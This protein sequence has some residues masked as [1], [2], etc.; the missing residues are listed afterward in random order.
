M[1]KG[2]YIALSGALL[3][4]KQLD[5]A[6]QNMANAA[7]SGY[8]KE[9]MSFRNSLIPVDNK[10]AYMADGR[11]MSEVSAVVT[12]FS[13]GGMMKTGNPLDMAIN[14]D[15]FFALEGNNYT[16]NGNFRI[17]G[18]GYLVT[19]DGKRVLGSGGPLTVQG[20]RID[21]SASGEIFVDD[22][23][24]GTLKIV[25]FPDKKVLKKLSGGVFSAKAAGSEI[26][27][28]IS[29]GYLEES[30]VETV[31]EMVQMMVSLREFEAYQKMIIAFDEASSKTINQLGK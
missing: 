17:D 15:G 28:E 26:N 16:R 21:V 7:T 5:V 27:T 2:I 20:G 23:S 22:I 3:K 8:K 19:Q 10:P 31:R 4:Q 1:Y 6:A 13:A 12:D 11:S 30:N 9:R 29:Q 14:G 18:E 25:D 24:V